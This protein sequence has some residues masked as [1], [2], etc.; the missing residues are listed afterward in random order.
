MCVCV[1][2]AFTFCYYVRMLKCEWRV[3]KN[4][5][6]KKHLGLNIALTKLN[7]PFFTASSC[8][9]FNK[10][11]LEGNHNQ[12]L[13]NELKN[14]GCFENFSGHV[15]MKTI[16]VSKQFRVKTAFYNSWYIHGSAKYPVVIQCSHFQ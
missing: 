4:Y 6:T 9:E 13:R 3:C 15:Y 1:C 2:S 5:N 14:S 16:K 8:S 7:L 12:P 11:H 10:K